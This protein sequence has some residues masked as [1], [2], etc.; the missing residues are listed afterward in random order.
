MRAEIVRVDRS[1]PWGSYVASIR[2]CGGDRYLTFQGDVDPPGEILRLR[3]GF[4]GITRKAVGPAR[5]VALG[6]TIRPDGKPLAPPQTGF[7]TNILYDGIAGTQLYV[8]QS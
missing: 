2:N 4:T 3:P 1:G 5:H 6:D 8:V 7:S